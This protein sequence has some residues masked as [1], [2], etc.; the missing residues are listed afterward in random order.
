MRYGFRASLGSTEIEGFA[1][2]EAG[3]LAWLGIRVCAVWRVEKRRGRGGL[4]SLV[5][6]R[7]NRRMNTQRLDGWAIN[8]LAP[9]LL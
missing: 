8:G 9:L 4:R 1:D 6:L 2:G 5:G 3:G 7:R